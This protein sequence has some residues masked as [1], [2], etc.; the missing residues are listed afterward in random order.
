MGLLVFFF[1]FNFSGI[2]LLSSTQARHTLEHFLQNILEDKLSTSKCGVL[3]LPRPLSLLLLSSLLAH[4]P[5]CTH[6]LALMSSSQN[7]NLIMKV[8]QKISSNPIFLH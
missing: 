3:S 4:K 2:S 6:T 8:S 1:F 7:D 5:T